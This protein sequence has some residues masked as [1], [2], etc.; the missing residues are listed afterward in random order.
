IVQIRTPQ[1]QGQRALAALA[2]TCPMFSEPSLNCLW[3]K[4]DSLR[5]LLR[6]LFTKD[7]VDAGPGVT[8]R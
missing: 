4:L 7:V 3:C 8:S 6:C 5:P 2:R 1:E